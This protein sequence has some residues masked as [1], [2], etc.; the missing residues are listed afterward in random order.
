M[1]AKLLDQPLPPTDAGQTRFAPAAPEDEAGI[2][3]LL[4]E[5]P[6]AGRIAITLE[7]EPDYFADARLPATEKQT[8]IAREDGRVVCTGSCAIREHFINGEPRRVGYL[9]G[10]RLDERSPVGLILCGAAMN[11]SGKRRPA[12]RRRFITPASPPTIYRHSDFWNV[13]CPECPPTNWLAILLPS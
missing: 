12:T 7:R 4:R 2:R 6:M 3:R 1:T 10:L 5:N 13:A 11:F 8:I 9:G